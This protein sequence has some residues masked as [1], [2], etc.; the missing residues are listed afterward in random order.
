M[1]KFRFLS[2]I[3]GSFSLLCR[4]S[5]SILVSLIARILS[6]IHGHLFCY[7][8]ISSAG[9]VLILPGFTVRKWQRL[10]LNEFP[11]SF[12]SIVI[13]ALELTS[14]NIMCGSVRMVYAIIYTL[15]LVS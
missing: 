13:S 12:P 6:T 4:I 14:R 3:S 10:T 2:S 1:S 11:G 7:S 5:V 15:F 8:A 9:V